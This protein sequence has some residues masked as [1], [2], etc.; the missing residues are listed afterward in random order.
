VVGLQIFDPPDGVA[1]VPSPQPA[2]LAILIDSWKLALRA[3]RKSPQTVKSYGDGV[4]AFLRWAERTGH[5][6]QLTKKN[7]QSFAADLLEDGAEASTALSRHLACRRFSAWLYA[8]GEIPL[9]ELVGV[10]G[11]KLDKK[12]VMPLSPE[13]LKALI[14]AC[15]GSGLTQRR[16]EAILRFMNESGARA[17]E[18]AAML[19]SEIRTVDG[20]AVIR[21]GKG[22]K[23]RIVP[24]GPQTARA[25]DRYIRVRRTHRLAGTDILWLGDRGKAFTYDALHKALRARAAQAGVEGFH[26]HRLRHTMADRWLSAGG[27]EAGLMA[28]AGWERP[29]MLLRYTRGRASARAVDEARRLGLG[30]L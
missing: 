12:V 25:L 1:A 4:A 11:P 30:E 3:E 26:P 17:G 24:F 22:G 16:D 9:D 20:T 14:A 29:E 6:A 10:R 27:S 5:P 19:L 2:D 23:G 18:T 8:E 21:R 13:E 7:L 15:A 28:V